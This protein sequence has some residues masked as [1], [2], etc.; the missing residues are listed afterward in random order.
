MTRTQRALVGAT[1]CAALSQGCGE[2]GPK[3]PPTAADGSPHPGEQTYVR[4]CSSCHA[5]GTG[6]APRVGDPIWQDIE[7][8][9]S[10]ALLATVKAG[11]PPGMPPMGMCK[12]CSDEELRD[13]I[14]YLL[15]YR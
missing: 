3:G 11:V 6:G 8:Q 2:A 14:D 1:V 12:R 7:K 15:R 9:G 10:D 4:F 13:A 5:R